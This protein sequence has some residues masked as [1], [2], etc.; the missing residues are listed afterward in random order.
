[1]L[2]LKNVG[3]RGLDLAA[4]ADHLRARGVVTNRVSAGASYWF[5]PGCRL[6]LEYSHSHA[7]HVGSN[8]VYAQVQL[9]F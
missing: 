1:M 7:Y 2:N 6:Q 8:A 9:A 3:V 5:Y 4:T